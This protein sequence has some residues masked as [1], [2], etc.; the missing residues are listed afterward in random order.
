[1]IQILSRFMSW[2][3]RPDT[4]HAFCSF[5]FCSQ[6]FSCLPSKLQSY[7][8]GILSWV[9]EKDIYINGL[10]Q[11]WSKS[12]TITIFFRKRKKEER[13]AKEPTLIFQCNI[14]WLWRTAFSFRKTEKSS[15]EYTKRIQL[16]E[17][18][19]SHSWGSETRQVLKNQMLK[20]HEFS[21]L[22]FCCYT[23]HFFFFFF[24][25]KREEENPDRGS[26]G[27]KGRRRRSRW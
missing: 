12:I 17:W 23:S 9:R 3:N 5:W 13:E 4:F 27:K 7:S 2:E 18:S 8:G 25:F 14:R 11:N 15:G 24:F 10:S 22:A 20:P 6:S 26:E 21:S 16:H 1:M 19:N